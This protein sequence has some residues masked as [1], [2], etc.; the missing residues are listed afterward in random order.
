M[1]RFGTSFTPQGPI[2]EAAIARAVAAMRS[3]CLH[4][5]NVD[6]GE[7]GPVADLERAFAAFLGQPYCLDVNVGGQALQI[8]RIIAEETARLTEAA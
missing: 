1:D 4:R 8:A 2:P 6:P 3:G 5:D 7:A